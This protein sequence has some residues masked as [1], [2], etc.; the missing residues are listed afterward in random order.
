MSAPTGKS[1]A[2]AGAQEAA[3]APTLLDALARA[4]AAAALVVAALQDDRANRYGFK[5][6]RNLKA[7]RLAHTQLRDAVGEAT[8]ALKVDFEVAADARLPT[9]ARWP[10]LEELTFVPGPDAADLEALALETWGALRTLRLG[11]YDRRS[12]ALDAPAARALAAALPRAPA[13]RALELYTFGICDAAAA[14]LFRAASAEAPLQLRALYLVG[15]ELALAGV[16]AL[17]A[18]GWRLEE[19]DL[20]ESC[21]LGSAGAAA[22]VAAPTFA[23]RR[24]GLI[25]CDLD[26]AA[27]SAIANAPWPLE[28]LN[29]SNNDFRAASVGP[30]LAA[31][32]RHARLRWLN[33]GLCSLSAAGFKALVEA[34][35]PALEHLHGV[36]A[37][38]KFDGPHALGAA[39]FAGFPALEVLDLTS[40]RLGAE[41]ARLLASRRWARLG[42]LTLNSCA[43]GDAGLAAL[44]RGQ[45][46]AVECMDLRSNGLSAPPALEDARRW[47]PALVDFHV[48]AH[49]ALDFDPETDGEPE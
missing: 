43:L 34:A 6:N 32:S 39:A 44:A 10:R 17:A 29:L 35:W 12:P 11:D 9:P 25:T 20:D 23:L 49:A 45:W 42:N 37:K 38:V 7:L 3:E 33:I 36:A 18:S 46:P 31:L 14:E 22:L 4:P 47:A 16:H 2:P 5:E 27:L 41:G 40:V 24:L 1:T 13:L 26:A 8:T 19:L 21:S 30:S 48:D 28:V 15:A